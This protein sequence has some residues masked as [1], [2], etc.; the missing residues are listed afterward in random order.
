MKINFGGSMGFKLQ[1][2]T[3][4]SIDSNAYVSIETEIPDDL[5]QEEIDKLSEKVNSILKKEA[6]K[7]TKEAY[8]IYSTK[9]LKIK[10]EAGF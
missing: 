7:R 9:L 1:A 10:K 4:E 6:I 8:E 3:Y 2:K 5:P